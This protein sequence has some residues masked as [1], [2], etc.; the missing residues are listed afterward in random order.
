[1]TV[2]IGLL[3]TGVAIRLT[4]RNRALLTN[5]AVPDRYVA[6]LRERLAQEPG[7]TE[8]RRVDAVYLGAAEVLVVADVHLEDGLDAE[9]VARAVDAARARIQ[10]EVPAIGRLALTPVP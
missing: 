1:V 10:E 6:R 9:A 3:L 5:Q 4:R 7:V 2:L 8:V